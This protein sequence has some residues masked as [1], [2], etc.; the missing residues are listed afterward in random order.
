MI[1]QI[2]NIIITVGAP[3]SGKSTWIE[4]F[5]SSHPYINVLSSDKLRGILGKSE[6]DQSVSADVFRYIEKEAE[7]TIKDGN[8]VL[9]DATNMHLKARKPWVEIAKKYNAKL[10][11]YV[12]LVD[13]ETLIK[14]NEKRGQSGGRNVPVDVI[15]KMLNNYVAP[16]KNEG[17]DE[18]NFI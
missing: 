9:I 13:R 16:S 3:G 18:V 1:N 7:N 5:K 2:N 14:R 17:F 4:K 6:D 15:D 11:A 8:D 10:I 12:F